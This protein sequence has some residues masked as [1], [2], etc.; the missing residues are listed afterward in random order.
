M[1]RQIVTTFIL[2]CT[3][4]LPVSAQHAVHLKNLHLDKSNHAAVGVALG[5]FDWKLG[6][7][8]GAAK[9]LSDDVADMQDFLYTC[10]GSTLS[11]WLGKDEPQLYKYNV[12][13][14]LLDGLSTDNAIRQGGFEA[15]Y[16]KYF[17]GDYPS[18]A[19]IAGFTLLRLWLL[20]SSKS[21][22]KGLRDGFQ[23]G[24]ALNG[25]LVV[26]ANYNVKFK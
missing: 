12:V 4:C 3:V 14:I 21:W 26:Y 7:A 10:A 1:N 11:H 17:I 23:W 13:M 24:T 19:K 2:M 8:A 20:D 6:C 25:T 15:G 9:E 22:S 16:P 18:T 5:A